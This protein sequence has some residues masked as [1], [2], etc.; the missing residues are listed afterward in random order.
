MRRTVRVTATLAFFRGGVYWWDAIPMVRGSKMLVRVK[1]RRC[2][3]QWCDNRYMYLGWVDSAGVAF[4]LL[5]P[6]AWRLSMLDYIACA[7]ASQ[8]RQKR[9]IPAKSPGCWY[10]E[11]RTSSTLKLKVKTKASCRPGNKTR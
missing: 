1:E 8:N 3:W 5:L 2:R 9:D 10:Y 6:I 11:G 4:A 7:A